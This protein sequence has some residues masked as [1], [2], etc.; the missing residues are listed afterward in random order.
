MKKMRGRFFI[1]FILLGF[2]YSGLAEANRLPGQDGVPPLLRSVLS[3][4]VREGIP[5]LRQ[6]FK[7]AIATR[8]EALRA[9]YEILGWGHELAILE[10]LSAEDPVSSLSSAVEPPPPAAFLE[11][12]GEQLTG[13]DLS[14]LLGWIRECR[15]SMRWD[16]TAGGESI[17]L[18]LHKEG[19]ASEEGAWE[20]RL[21]QGLE[22]SVALEKLEGLGQSG[23]PGALR[24]TPDGLFDLVVGPYP[25]FLEASRVFSTL[26]RVSG[27]HM[28]PPPSAQSAPPLF[29][30]A[31]VTRNL[32]VLPDV[33]FATELGR[34]RAFLS[35]LALAFEAEGGINGGFFSSSGPV[36]TLVVKGIPFHQSYGERSAIGLAPGS[37]P[38]FGNG[39]LT[40]RVDTKNGPVNLDRLNELP[41]KDEISLFLE[42]SPFQGPNGLE[43]R[44]LV[45]IPVAAEIVGS[46]PVPPMGGVL[47][48]PGESRQTEG[49]EPGS[50]VTVDS[51]WSN[52]RF[53]GS[54]LV[55]Q[56]GPGIIENGQ[57]NMA[58]ESFDEKTRLE[59]HP[60]SMVG[61]DGSALW[62]IV[63]DGRNSS[64][65]LGLTLQDSAAM[66]LSLGLTEVLNLDGG[67]SSSIWWRNGLVS[68][69]SGG[70]E[71]P[72]PY[73]ILFGTP[74]ANPLR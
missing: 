12:P 73:A 35:E 57:A 67:G 48:Y 6:G 21:E 30:A 47:V 36:G 68:C 72:I 43:S 55:L 5:L 27:M 9:A 65:S 15:I 33:R 17:D 49:I 61:W 53:G 39:G 69:P 28:A 41:R 40:L 59:R 7:G 45:G 46:L 8:G 1:L 14:L 51:I 24:K 37:P 29:W 11:S 23:W 19:I 13:E 22:E 66:A 4:T 64:H 52:P 10:R 71:R 2:L 74:S 20:V 32:A 31:I 70:K 16:F 56:A 34:P 18:R 3:D 50:L 25:S 62:W 63:V 42:N 44:D 60:R 38:V 26:P 58:S 54:Q